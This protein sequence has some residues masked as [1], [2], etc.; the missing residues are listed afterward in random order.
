MSRDKVEM[1][2][3]APRA[4]AKRFKKALAK[5]HF[6]TQSEFF[7]FKMMELADESEKENKRLEKEVKVNE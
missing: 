7:R 2:F 6:S 5:S 3:D 1:H 4:L